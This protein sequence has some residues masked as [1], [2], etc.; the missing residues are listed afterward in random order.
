MS[1]LLSSIPSIS[2]FFPCLG[3]TKADMAAHP[4][5]WV[6]TEPLK[7]V[8]QCCRLTLWVPGTP[9]V[10]SLMEVNSRL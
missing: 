3:R 8:A 10:A 6:C 2:C 1:G 7:G 4:R 5:P 9:E